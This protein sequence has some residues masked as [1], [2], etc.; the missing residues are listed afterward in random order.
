MYQI[1]YQ[2]ADFEIHGCLGR[3]L[4]WKVAELVRDI[5][6]SSSC[7]YYFSRTFSTHLD[8]AIILH[9]QA[10]LSNS[11]R[12]CFGCRCGADMAELANGWRQISQV[13]NDVWCGACSKLH[14]FKGNLHQYEWGRATAEMH[15]SNPVDLGIAGIEKH[16]FIR[17]SPF[18]RS[19]WIA[20]SSNRSS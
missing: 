1:A 11:E 9:L 4:V 14:W 5:W 2:A 8:K 19:A 18:I 16:I 15:A 6:W 10:I 12:A 7:S 20:L 17:D 3:L 13:Q